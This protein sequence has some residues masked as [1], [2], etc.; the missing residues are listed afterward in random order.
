[1][2][3]LQT[4][5]Y[6][7]RQLPMYQRQGTVAL[8]KDLGNI[9]ALMD[10][11]G[12]PHTMFKSIHIAGTNGKGTTAHIIAAG[13]QANG[14]RVGMYTSPHYI[15]FRERIKINGTFIGKEEVVL[16]VQKYKYLFEKIR[17]SFFEM[18][19]AMA[20]YYFAEQDVDIAIIEVGLGGRLD[21][22]NIITPLLSIITNISYD[23]Q[24]MLGDTLEE[25]AWEKAG[26][27]KNGIDTIKGETQSDIEK[28][29]TEK[30]NRVGCE[31]YNADSYTT[32][33]PVENGYAVDINHK[34]WIKKLNTNLTSTVQKK[35]LITALYSLHRLQNQLGLLPDKIAEGITNMSNLTYYIGRYQVL[36]ERPFVLADSAHNIA[37]VQELLSHMQNYAY[38]SLHVVLG[39]VNDKD[40]SKVLK[41]LPNTATY[42]F[43]KADIPRG[44]PTEK[45][46]EI[47][48]GHGLIG[49]CHSSVFEG[50][51]RSLS[52]AKSEDMVL[53]M[54]S[55]FVVAE[56][57]ASTV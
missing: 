53:V 21:S 5:D 20:F 36:Q 55:I 26:I 15:D 1:M 52:L 31:L 11:M 17:P 46:Q 48:N 51:N 9:V 14:L 24:A 10:A 3:Y 41:L 12:D 2:N 39:M 30:K 40:I 7:Y 47:A 19:V 32:L 38:K 13:L 18:T 42:H 33:K 54:G 35:N 22:T 49:E 25:I 8:K 45:L 37:G 44:M 16:F 23:H 29:F 56:V 27:M 34:L 50:Y 57:L 6:M 43:V 4:L 28:I